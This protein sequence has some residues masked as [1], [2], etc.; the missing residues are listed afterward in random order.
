[1]LVCAVRRT[2][3]DRNKG[4]QPD[5]G[6]R[7][8]PRLD[9]SFWP[10]SGEKSSSKS[11]NFEMAAFA[12]AAR[13]LA[14]AGVLYFIHILYTWSIQKA[15]TGFDSEV[16]RGHFQ[17]LVVYGCLIFSESNYGEGL[18]R[19]CLLEPH[20]PHGWPSGEPV[21]RPVRISARLSLLQLLHLLCVFY[22]VFRLESTASVMLHCCLPHKQSPLCLPYRSL[23][24]KHPL[25]L[26]S[27]VLAAGTWTRAVLLL[28]SRNFGSLECANTV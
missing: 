25:S 14:L 10:P 3:K 7:R 24:R 20:G 18:G 2:G 13:Q 5:K 15:E 9:N 19:R 23:I 28:V 27:A 4:S 21:D 22:I 1:M 17:S 6:F 11:S 26:P 16:T 12:K 8:K